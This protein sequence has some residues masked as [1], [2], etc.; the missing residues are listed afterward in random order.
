MRQTTDATSQVICSIK[1]K[2]IGSPAWKFCPFRQDFGRNI[3]TFFLSLRQPLQRNFDNPYLTLCIRLLIPL[4]LNNLR[5][6]ILHE[7]FIT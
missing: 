1:K 7:T 4:I 5:L 6:R 3:N 2:D